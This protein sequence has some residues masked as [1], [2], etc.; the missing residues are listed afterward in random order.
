[1]NLFMLVRSS[2]RVQI[3]ELL[4]RP[5]FVIPTL[6]FPALFFTLFDLPYAQKYPQ[7]AP[8]MMLSY[9]AF[10]IIGVTLFQ[11]GV[12]MSVDR[13]LPWERY[14]RTLPTPL[15]IRFASRIIV[16]GVFAC[17]AGAGV[18]AVAS[19]AT[20]ARFSPEQWLLVGL[21][22][23]IGAVPFVLF[24]MAIGYWTSPK[25][26]VPIAN[27]FYLLLSFAGGLWYP[28]SM[29]PSFAKAISPYTPTRQFGDLLWNAPHGVAGVPLAA[30]AA[31]AMLF[32][33]VAAA[34]YR[35]DRA[36]RFA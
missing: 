11:F 28:P 26:A 15:W 5:A 33:A 13:V 35:R 14:L 21:C 4:R 29:L 24:G 16:A 32:A 25:A 31:F 10:A 36:A 22:A 20:S 3:L 34:G 1:M 30:L 23:L 7:A 18:V 9:I 19:I 8:A 12:G 27:I 6:A 2:V 17:L